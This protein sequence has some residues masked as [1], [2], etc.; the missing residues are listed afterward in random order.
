[1]QYNATVRAVLSIAV[2]AACHGGEAKPPPPQA[3]PVE[4]ATLAPTKVV[5]AS[6][7]MTTLRPLTASAL[8]PQIEGHVTEIRVHAG[9]T[10]AAGQVLMQID[11]GPQPAAVARARA[12]RASRVAA[13]ELTERNLGRVRELVGKGALPQQELDNAQAAATSARSDVA[14]LGA[15][16]ASSA[17]QLRYYQITAPAP[18]VVGD[19]T[20]RVGDLVTP[21]TKLTSV[22]DNHV[23]EANMAVPVERAAAVK[24]GLPVEIIGDDSRV[25]AEGKVSFISPQVNPET[26]SVLVKASIAN[27]DGLLR[28]EQLTRG[29]IVWRTRDG[30]TVPALAVTRVGGQAFVYVA[31]QTPG[32]LVAR[33][34]PVTLGELLNIAYVVERGVAAGDRIVVS[35]V[36]KLRDGAPIAQ[37]PPGGGSG[38]TA[39]AAGAAAGSAAG[40]PGSGPGAGAAG[41]GSNRNPPSPGT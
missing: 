14:A 39:G 37:A 8:Q 23:L 5:D 30:I 15:E 41:S 27:P 33:Q 3:M 29:R 4:I 17:V 34:R 25:V 28:A 10:V 35:Q 18:G 22:T 11:P 32:G 31:T 24:P 16:I 40:G 1:M 21:Q 6:D 19:I 12:T 36:Q 2:L 38:A 7:Y 26:Q 13:L 20:V 9:D